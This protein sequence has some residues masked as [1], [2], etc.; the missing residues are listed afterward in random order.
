MNYHYL[1]F[2]SPD[3]PVSIELEPF[4][5]C[6]DVEHRLYR[7]DDLISASNI[8]LQNAVSERVLCKV[9]IN[10][11][12][13]LAAAVAAGYS[14]D[15]NSNF[16]GIF[17]CV[18]DNIPTDLP[19]CS[20]TIGTLTNT[21]NSTD[22]IS[23]LIFRTPESWAGLNR[24]VNFVLWFIHDGQDDYVVVP[25]RIFTSTQNN[26][27]YTAETP[28]TD[29]KIIKNGVEVD[30]LCL[31]GAKDVIEIWAEH[32]QVDAEALVVFQKEGE[33]TSEFDGYDSTNLDKL[34]ESPFLSM[35]SELISGGQR[36]VIRINENLIKG[37]ECIFVVIKPAEGVG[38]PTPETCDHEFD[39]DIELTLYKAG[40]P[41][42]LFAKIDYAIDPD[43]AT[44]S[45]VS[46]TI[47]VLTCEDT[48]T[49][50]LN[51]DIIYT[52]GIYCPII[53]TVLTLSVD[54]VTEGGCIYTATQYITIPISFDIHT[55]IITIT[56]P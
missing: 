1:P 6:P 55:E 8:I 34:T 22:W 17:I 33:F 3:I 38:P 28:F 49:G 18:T 13:Y 16:N 42:K 50:T 35:S 7:S 47:K 26:L 44:L 27:Q 23:T 15:F 46:F 30:E 9:T 52:P 53:G 20:E 19:V 51:D 14:G 36:E 29:L 12:D 2:S 25:F 24:Y 43:I 56:W 32:D 11:A 54:V 37:G 31:D 39:L 10:F 41:Q 5:F 4:D 45:T 40:S 48:V 21:S